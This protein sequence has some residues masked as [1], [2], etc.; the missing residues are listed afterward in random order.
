MRDIA[1]PMIAFILTF[2]A[3]TFAPLALIVCFFLL[4]QFWRFQ[5]DNYAFWAALG[6]FLICVQVA[7]MLL[8]FADNLLIA[9]DD[10]NAPVAPRDEYT[11]DWREYSDQITRYKRWAYYRRTRQFDKLAALEQEERELAAKAK[12][13]ERN[14][15]ATGS[16][17]VATRPADSRSPE[18]SRRPPERPA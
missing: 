6:A 3:L 4:S 14:G 16:T 5:F 7:R 9:P 13:R 2:V 12:T 18:V 1:R 10:P 8:R 11:H 17:A 15:Q